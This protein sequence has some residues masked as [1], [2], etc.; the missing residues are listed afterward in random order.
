M[1][2]KF[3]LGLLPGLFLATNARAQLYDAEQLILDVQ[4]LSQ[5]KQI[6]Q[7]LK[8]G[9][10]ILDAGY[11]AIR[12]V[13]KGSFTLHQAYLDGLLA[14]SPAIRAYHR[15]IAIAD[16][17]ASLVSKYQTAWS[18]FR[19]KG[20]FHPEELTLIGQVYSGLLSSSLQNLSDLTNI[21]TDGV[22]RASDAERMRQIDA[23]YISMTERLSFI[24]RFNNS[25]FLL[26]QQHQGSVNENQTLQ[27]LYDIQP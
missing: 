27:Q 20:G 23:I 19:E 9:Y 25:T 6:L 7:D 21:L 18:F 26:V 22:L 5:L 8:Q 24:D 2:I 15:V 13:A 16:L 14:V 10:A 4:K 17:Q 1:K 3:F 12:D 11:S